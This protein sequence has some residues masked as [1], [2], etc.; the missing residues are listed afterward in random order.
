MTMKSAWFLGVSLMCINLFVFLVQPGGEEFVTL[1]GS[2][3]TPICALFGVLGIIQAVKAFKVMDNAK[4]LWIWLLAGIGCFFIA[5]TTYG[6]MESVLGIDM[7]ETFPSIADIFYIAA[8]IPIGISMYGFRNNFLKSGMPLGKWKQ[9]LIPVFSILALIFTGAILSIFLPIIADQ[10]TELLP[11]IVY[12]VY[13]LGDFIILIPALIMVYLMSLFGKGIFSKPW[14]LIA[15]GY[16]IADLI[17][18]YISWSGSY[19][20]GSFI[21]FG[22]NIAYIL[23]AIGGIYQKNIIAPSK[24][25]GGAQ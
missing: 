14:Q 19:S 21:D 7:D 25:E 10:D 2:F 3:F 13:P 22:W 6:I 24:S 11:K 12:M 9:I 20:S 8:Y 15:T 16:T 4:K 17:Y 1:F 18:A 23:I 5:D